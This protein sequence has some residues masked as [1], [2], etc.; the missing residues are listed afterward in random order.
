MNLIE[1]L[2]ALPGFE[3]W[4][5]S[6]RFLLAAV[7]G[8]VLTLSGAQASVVS[9]TS[10]SAFQSVLDASLTIIDTSANIGKTTAQLSTQTPGAEFF[11]YSSYV[12]NDAL[13]L[14]GFGF[15]G[16]VNNAHVGLNFAAGVSGV[17]V[18]TNPADGGRILAYS[19]LNGTGALLGMANFG[20]P[21]GA[22]LF[23]GLVSST[24]IKSAI[25][26]CDFNFDLKCGLFN[27]MFGRTSVTSAVPV[28]AALPLL[29]SALAF[30]GFLGRR[31]T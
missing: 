13:I 27:P 7:F 30:F 11:G 18:S 14:N 25:F 17:G 5:V 1:A 4:R 10:V 8:A 28:P 20:T 9:Y 26:T 29:F 16:D 6:V 19:G 24:L 22:Q 21:A 3:Y 2:L 12:R 31:R 23:G 15:S